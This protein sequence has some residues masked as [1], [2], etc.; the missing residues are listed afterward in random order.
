MQQS[1]APPSLTPPTSQLLLFPVSYC[2]HCYASARHSL[3]Y[4]WWWQN[5]RREYPFHNLDDIYSWRKVDIRFIMI[6]SRTENH[7]AFSTPR[8]SSKYVV[9]CPA[10]SATWD[11]RS[12]RSVGETEQPGLA[13]GRHASEVSRMTSSEVWRISTVLREFTV[14]NHHWLMI[15]ANDLN[16]IALLDLVLDDTLGYLLP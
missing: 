8:E 12:S 16:N 6:R 4:P 5:R 3:K 1:A 15:P 9:R 11:L 7:L 13:T 14:V 10:A 2:T